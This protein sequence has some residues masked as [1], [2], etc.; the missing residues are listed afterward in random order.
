MRA[1]VFAGA[2]AALEREG[3]SGGV[4]SPATAG[5]VVDTALERFGR[6]DTARAFDNRWLMSI[7]F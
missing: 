2:T 5:Q 4:R 6:I 3:G 1:R 7:A